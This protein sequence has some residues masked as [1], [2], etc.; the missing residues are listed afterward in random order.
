[1]SNR[2]MNSSKALGLLIGCAIATGCTGDDTPAT[3]DGTGSTTGGPA[4]TSGSEDTS[5][6]SSSTTAVDTTTGS[7]ETCFDGV[8]NQDETDVDCGGTVCPPCDTSQSCEDGSDCASL[9]CDNGMCRLPACDDGVKNGDETDLDCGGSCLPC[10]P[11]QNCV[12]DDDCAS[13][14]CSN[15][16]CIAATCQDGLQNGTETD[17]DCGGPGCPG[18]PE[19]GACVENG[20]CATAF[21]D[22]GTCVAVE[23]LV[24]ANCSHLSGTCIVGQCNQATHECEAANAF[25]GAACNDG[26][27]CTNSSCNEGICAGPP[28]NCSFLDAECALGMCEEGVGCVQQP[29]ND[30]DLCEDSDACTTNTTCSEGSCVGGE[31]VD[32]T[33]LDT[34]C[35]VGVCNQFNGTCN[36]ELVPDGTACDDAFA[37]STNGS[38]T[39]GACV[40]DNLV[41]FWT[42]D[43]ANNNAGWTLDTEWA[44]GPASGSNCTYNG[45]DPSQDH[46]QAGDN[47]VAG[48]VIGG[49]ASQ[50]AHPFY[51]LTS[52][53]I[54][55]TVVAGPVL[56]EFY[57]HLHSDY[58]PFMQNTI[59]V[60]DGNAWVNIWAS[61]S[62]P[63][64]DDPDWVRIVHELSNFKHP[65]FQMRFGFDAS[66]GVFQVASWNIDDVHL[67]S[68]P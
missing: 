51:Y 6:S 61:G 62:F 53:V 58:T 8:R 49:C 19:G 36:P 65:N 64:V 40:P 43:F 50:T 55:T 14:L 47:G 63:G 41:P 35:Q 9:V 32:C 67:L 59:D 22:E 10:G 60:F 18:C 12:D 13:G 26:D 68:C 2:L 44:I 5:T 38:C 3:V 46:T 7:E 39:A 4:T 31:A 54:D 27:P 45:Q 16:V 29:L 42:E 21:C 57:R 37:C 66:G 24:N 17:I 56:L 34:G 48:V 23:C 28:I 33:Y 1:M 25:Q 30:G 15:E 52:P 11:N 20:D